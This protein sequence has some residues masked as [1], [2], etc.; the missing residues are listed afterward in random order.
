[1]EAKLAPRKKDELVGKKRQKAS[2]PCSQTK[3]FVV[4]LRGSIYA[5]KPLVLYKFDE[6]SQGVA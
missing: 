1:M 6:I 4:F 3:Y 2:L 5:K